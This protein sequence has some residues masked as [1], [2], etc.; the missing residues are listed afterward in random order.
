VSVDPLISLTRDAYGYGNNNPITFS[1]PSGLRACD[2]PR[3]CGPV[4][5]SDGSG[6]S[7]S[8]GTGSSSPGT[9]QTPL[10]CGAASFTAPCDDRPSSTPSVN[11]GGPPTASWSRVGVYLLGEGDSTL[12]STQAAT[13]SLSPGST[14]DRDYVVVVHWMGG[15]VAVIDVSL[16][17]ND[18]GSKKVFSLLNHEAVFFGRMNTS[19]LSD[20]E[21][22]VRQ[23]PAGSGAWP[24]SRL[25]EQP[26]LSAV[27]VSTANEATHPTLVF[28]E[29]YRND[30]SPATGFSGVKDVGFGWIPSGLGPK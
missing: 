17:M 15:S 22:L 26:P 18:A 7:S 14:F 9:V 2:D 20:F 3:N 24:V 28:I 30:G 19:D 16:S 4:A 12:G 27:S 6:G 5:P 11:V 23:M 8:S 13:I 1:D 29:V 21:F 25:M 10:F